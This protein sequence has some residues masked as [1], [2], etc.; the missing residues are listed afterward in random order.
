MLTGKDGARQQL[1]SRLSLGAFFGTSESTMI[2]W[3]KG[4]VAKVVGNGWRQMAHGDNAV[5]HGGA[6]SK[7]TESLRNLTKK[8]E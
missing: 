5:A 3:V 7:L 2:F 4:W 8:M 1:G 6:H